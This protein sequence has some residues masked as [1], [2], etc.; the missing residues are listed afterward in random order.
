MSYENI[1]VS[2]FKEKVASTPNA[3]ILDVRT[4]GELI[5]G[6]I[7]NHIMINLMSPDFLEKIQELNKEKTYFLYCRSGGRSER[8]CQMMEGLGFEKLYNLMGGIQAW[9]Q[10]A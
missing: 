4:E 1:S 7:P 3:V 8:A 2:E 5:E 6:E 9:N 10:E